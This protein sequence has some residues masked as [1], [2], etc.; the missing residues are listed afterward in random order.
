LN[1]FASSKSLLSKPKSPLNS[2]RQNTYN[3]MDPTK[4]SVFGSWGEKN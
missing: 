1:C 4:F 3:S 2:S